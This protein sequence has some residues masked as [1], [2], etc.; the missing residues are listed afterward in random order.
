MELPVIGRPR[1]Q[2]AEEMEALTSLDVDWRSG[3]IWSFVYFAGD[4]VAQVLK[5]AYTTFFYTNGLSPMAFRSL[6]KFESEVIAMT[7]SLLGCS[8]A[9]GNMTSGGTESI[10]MVVKAARDWA[11]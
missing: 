11:R 10:L 1:D 9:V 4:D 7:A 6:K 3:K 8:E 2:L 5:D